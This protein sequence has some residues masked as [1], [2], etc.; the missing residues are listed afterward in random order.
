MRNDAQGEAKKAVWEEFPGYASMGLETPY[1][2]MCC[3]ESFQVLLEICPNQI[4]NRV[5][6]QQGSNLCVSI[7]QNPNSNPLSLK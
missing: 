3:T 7:L 4:E 5:A 1:L 6:G 2:L